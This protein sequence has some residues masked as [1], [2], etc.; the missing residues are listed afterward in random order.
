MQ[1]VDDILKNIHTTRQ[2]KLKEIAARRPTETLCTEATEAVLNNEPL[3]SLCQE[4]SPAESIKKKRAAVKKPTNTTLHRLQSVIEERIGLFDV[5]NKAYVNRTIEELKTYHAENKRL[6][7]TLL[8][9]KKMLLRKRDEWA[10][11]A[12]TIVR[13]R[14]AQ[15]IVPLTQRVEKDWQ[16]LRGGAADIPI[17]E[18]GAYSRVKD[19]DC[20]A[21]TLSRAKHWDQSQKDHQNVHHLLRR[22]VHDTIDGNL[23]S[24]D[25]AMVANMNH[26]SETL[27]ERVK[28]HLI[29][30]TALYRSYD[31]PLYQEFKLLQQDLV[32]R[33]IDFQDVVASYAVEST[34]VDAKHRLRLRD[35]LMT[36]F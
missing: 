18:S 13:D 1:S 15:T 9:Q 16:S 20:S 32:E 28:N 23:A 12:D 33:G 27:R 22:T 35:Y 26:A 25:E 36:L 31:L 11:R 8:K 21:S 14:S 30:A 5:V 2:E 10:K 6:N 34:R 7:A 3:Q 4:L 19:T 24:L 17:V 29:E